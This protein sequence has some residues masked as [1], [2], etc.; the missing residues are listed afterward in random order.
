MPSRAGLV[1]SAGFGSAWSCSFCQ[2]TIADAALWNRRDS[3]HCVLSEVQPQ[4][5]AH[6]I[7]QDRLFTFRPFCKE[8][9][10]SRKA[11]CAGA[12]ETLRHFG[13]IERATEKL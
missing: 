11:C 5:L 1:E 8:W 7:G 10:D 2:K 4:S 12:G 13:L 9:V 3:H 6:Y